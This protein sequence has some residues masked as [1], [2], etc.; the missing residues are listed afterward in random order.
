MN[1]VLTALPVVIYNNNENLAIRLGSI[2][3]EDFFYHMLYMGA[4]L[5][6]YER[7]LKRKN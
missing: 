4:I 3:I 2:P 6:L 5:G 1:G 7:Q